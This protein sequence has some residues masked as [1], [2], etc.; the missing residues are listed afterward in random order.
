[1]YEASSENQI[2]DEVR[3]NEI[4]P[5]QSVVSRMMKNLDNYK[6][7][8]ANEKTRQTDQCAVCMEEFTDDSELAELKCNSAHIFLAECIKDWFYQQKKDHADFSCPLCRDS[9]I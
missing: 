2:P 8:E 3:L 9:V 5:K 4:G 7:N 6:F 1:M